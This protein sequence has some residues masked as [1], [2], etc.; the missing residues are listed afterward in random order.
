MSKR[1]IVLVAAILAAAMARLIP[2]PP[3]LTPIG[4]MALFGGACFLSR[5][6]SYLLPIVAMLLSDI[7]LGF[8]RSGFERMLA[9]QPIVYVCILAYT[10]LGQCIKDRRSVWQVGGAALAGSILFFVVTNF[11]VWAEGQWYPLTASGLAECY[12]KAIPYFRDGTLPGDLG[13]TALLFGGLAVLEDRVAW[14]RDKAASVP[15]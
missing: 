15:A 3:N 9:I 6:R 5:M 1:T 14:M 8:S 7:V 10:A 2:H 11:A 12:I 13:F 4:A